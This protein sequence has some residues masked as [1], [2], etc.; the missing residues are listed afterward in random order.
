[1]RWRTTDRVLPAVLVS[2]Q[3]IL[4][5]LRK[6]M[7]VFAPLVRDHRFYSSPKRDVIVLT[8]SVHQAEDEICTGHGYR[9]TCFAARRAA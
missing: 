5:P 9:M 7:M 8:R 6:K 2:A 4:K 3:S 1:M